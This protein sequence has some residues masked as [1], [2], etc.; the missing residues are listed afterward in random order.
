MSIKMVDV[1]KHFEELFFRRL[2]KQDMWSKNNIKSIFKI[3]LERDIPKELP[4]RDVGIVSANEALLLNALI[5]SLESHQAIRQNIEAMDFGEAKH[6]CLHGEEV[7]EKFI[8]DNGA[9]QAV[10]ADEHK[11]RD[12][13][14]GN[15]N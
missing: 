5:L 12:N 13:N 9:V 7:L 1:F 10:L 8:R 15:I 11:R 3:T 2:D 14:D 6:L 4:K